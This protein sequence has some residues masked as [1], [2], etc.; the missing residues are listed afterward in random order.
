MADSAV[1]T[2]TPSV[3]EVKDPKTYFS[4]DEGTLKAIEITGGTATRGV[5]RSHSSP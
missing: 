3:L 2:A 1:G 5:R 4:V